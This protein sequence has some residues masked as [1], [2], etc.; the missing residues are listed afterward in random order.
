[1]A[2]AGATVPAGARA[3]AGFWL[4]P[5]LA[6][7]G[8]HFRMRSTVPPSISFENVYLDGVGASVSLPS[9]FSGFSVRT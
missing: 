5:V 7:R 9:G 2:A 3:S 6:R 4:P 1:M 8:R